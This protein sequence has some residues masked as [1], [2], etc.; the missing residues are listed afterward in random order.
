MSLSRCFVVIRVSPFPHIQV[1]SSAGIAL[2]PLKALAV[3]HNQLAHIRARGTDSVAHHPDFATGHRH[4]RQGSRTHSRNRH[5]LPT[6]A[7]PVLHQRS[8]WEPRGGGGTQWLEKYSHSP[9]IVRSICRARYQVTFVRPHGCARYPAP[10]P[11]VPVYDES[12][13]RPAALWNP[14]G[15]DTPG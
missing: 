3:R 11:P 6:A 1:G 5:A 8:A 7:I 13:I 4:T 14:H 10:L 15:P 12:R 2:A 9:N